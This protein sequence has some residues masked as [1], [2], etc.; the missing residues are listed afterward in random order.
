MHA[1][2][3]QVAVVAGAA[4]GTWRGVARML[5]EAGAT[6]Y[7]TGRSARGNPPADGPYAGRPE[8]I[9]ETAEMVDASGGNGIAVR[10]DHTSEPEVAALFKRV[11]R[12][13]K[14]L[15][16]LVNVLGGAPVTQWNPFWKLSVEEGRAFFDGWFW[17]HVLT[18]RYA[19]PLMV[20]RKAGL[21][22]EM[23]DGHSLGYRGQ[24]YFDLAMTM[25][26][27]LSNGLA[28]ELLP[29]GV[30]ALSITPGFLRSEATLDMFGVT[31]SN[32]RDALDKKQAQ[33]FGWAGSE[34]PC[35][36]GRAIVA[37]A[38]DPNLQRKSGGVYSS[39]GL[40]EEYGFTDVDG[41]RPHWGRFGAENFPHIFAGDGHAPVLWRAVAS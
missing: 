29:H 41:G 31:E 21:I 10:V 18:C 20:E 15:D 9:E 34:T 2:A 4:R 6:V 13:Q 27:R 26:K 25:L 8:T 1:M 28:E 5:G 23:N 39:W 40:S 32:W 33:Q 38:T 30:T 14:R 12:E 11:K 19:A 36:V 35:F 16:V 17:K 37:L 24:F 3:G 22:V 7:C